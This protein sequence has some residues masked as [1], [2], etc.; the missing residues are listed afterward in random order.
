MRE[1]MKALANL[2]AL[3]RFV[4]MLTDSRSSERLSKGGWMKKTVL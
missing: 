3:C 2:G 4:G 1:Q